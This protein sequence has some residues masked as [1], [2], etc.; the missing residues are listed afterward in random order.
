MESVSRRML[1]ALF[2]LASALAASPAS[3]Q[4]LPV[5]LPLPPLPPPSF[6]ISPRSERI[7]PPVPFTGPEL[8]RIEQ[9]PH[10]SAAPMGMSSP[11]ATM[12]VRVSSDAD[13]EALRLSRIHETWY[14]WET[15][16][17]D[18]AAVA[19]LLLGAD[20]DRRPPTLD[21][22][23]APRPIAFAAVASGVYAAGPPILHFAR[24]DA[25]RGLASAGLRIAMPL[26]GFALGSFAGWAF[27]SQ[28]AR[29]SADGSLGAIVGG[30]AA[31]AIDASAFGWQRWYGSGPTARTPVL[32]ARGSF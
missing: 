1:L 5:P 15:L 25:W 20:V 13:R 7:E 21:D 6:D 16:A 11:A 2:V 9:V 26:V 3:A 18:A 31:M 23:P 14:G 19:V 27:Q 12:G 10:D 30:V 17:C 29:A 4:P 28:P 24:G 32:G 22:A 8:E